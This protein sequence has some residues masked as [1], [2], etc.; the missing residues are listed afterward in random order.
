MIEEYLLEQ[1]RWVSAKELSRRFAIGQRAFRREGKRAGLCSE[2][3]ISGDR[4]YRHLAHCTEK[5]WARFD[6]RI[7]DHAIGELQR[8]K[9]LRLKRR[10]LLN[11]K[12]K[13]FVL[14]P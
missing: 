8:R 6:A 2:F 14:K 3:A 9:R 11:R 4:G 5:E 12:E 1:R 13:E 7:G 10:E